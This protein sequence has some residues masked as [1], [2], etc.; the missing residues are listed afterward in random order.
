MCV[1]AAASP[2]RSWRCA[3]ASSR[4]RLP[5]TKASS[6]LPHCCS[7]S[8]AR[9]PGTRPTHCSVG[10]AVFGTCSM[11]NPRKC[12]ALCRVRYCIGPQ[13]RLIIGRLWNGTGQRPYNACHSANSRAA[14]CGADTRA[15]AG[16][17]RFSSGS[18]YS[19]SWLQGNGIHGAPDTYRGGLGAFRHFACTG[20]E[21]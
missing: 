15:S 2:V 16:S 20:C 1:R 5:I 21:R 10:S 14:A 13:A 7:C 18:S 6:S 11:S 3:T 9:R 19:A 8:G 17:F 12:S 4:Q